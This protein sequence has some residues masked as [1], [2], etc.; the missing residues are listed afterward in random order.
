MGLIPLFLIPAAVF[1]SMAVALVLV[2]GDVMPWIAQHSWGT[3]AMDPWFQ[4]LL[5]LTL[6]ILLVV[7]PLASLLTWM[8]RKQSAMMQD[9]IGPNRAGILG[10]R[11][12][13]IPHFVADAV[14]MIMKEDFVPAKANRFLFTLAPLMAIIPVFV[15]FAIVPFGATV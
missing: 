7:M 11:G 14:K 13:G 3:W 9:R 4:A 5:K 6:L 1:T 12:W 8:E 15:T 10:W 2:L